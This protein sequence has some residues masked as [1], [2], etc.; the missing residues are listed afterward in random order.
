MPVVRRPGRSGPRIRALAICTGLLALVAAIPEGTARNRTSRASENAPPMDPVA[1]RRVPVPGTRCL[2]LPANNIW[3]A[4]ISRLPVHRMSSTWLRSMRASWS[5]LHPAFGRSPY[6]MPFKVVSNLHPKVYVGFEYWSESDRGPYPFGLDIPLERNED[7]HALM[8]NRDTCTLYE[9]Y[10]A[11]WNRARP[12][13]GSGAIYSLG[14]NR[15]RPNGWTSADAA[16]LPIFPGLLRWDEA[17]SGY[18]SHAIR[19]TTPMTDCRHDWPARHHVGGCNRSYPPMGARFRLKAGFNIAPFGWRVRAVLR[20]MKR[21]GMIIADRGPNWY[22]GGT[23]DQRWTNTFL[24]QIKRIP[25]SAF[26]VVDVRRCIINI[27]SAAASC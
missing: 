22:V 7:R 10:R 25:A 15:L 21:Y 4:D 18:I 6:G 8:I 17:S 14:S 9:L 13:A 3:N 19:F 27:N 12:R 5:R 23:M 26:V 11:D 2:V 24:N 1:A 20:A 16:G